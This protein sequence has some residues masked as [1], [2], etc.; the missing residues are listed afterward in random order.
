[1]LQVVILHRISVCSALA[2]VHKFQSS[3]GKIR[4]HGGI[5]FE[6]VQPLTDKGLLV[7]AF[8]KVQGEVWWEKDCDRHIHVE[9]II[10][11]M[12]LI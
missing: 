1:M 4:Q 2:V 6:A 8:H 9:D 10:K 11:L 7:L 12:K 3:N 5:S